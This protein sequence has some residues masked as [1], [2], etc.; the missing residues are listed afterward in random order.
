MNI[1]IK[2][3][4]IENDIMQHSLPQK[5]SR[6]HRWLTKITGVLHGN[7]KNHILA[8][9]THWR[10]RTSPFRVNRKWKYQ[11]LS[12]QL[13]P[14]RV[15]ASDSQNTIFWPR[16]DYFWT[17]EKREVYHAWVLLFSD[18]V[19]IIAKQTSTKICSYMLALTSSNL[20]TF[21]FFPWQVRAWR[22]L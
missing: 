21:A 3:R 20:L 17:H 5:R 12:C 2:N 4:I 10:M 11:L 9:V 22:Q 16:M 19:K 8:F 15:T 18:V 6:K 13:T 1:H 14:K 7:N